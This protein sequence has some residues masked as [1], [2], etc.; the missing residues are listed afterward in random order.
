[1]ERKINVIPYTNKKEDSKNLKMKWTYQQKEERVFI[2]NFSI[3]YSKKGLI[4]HSTVI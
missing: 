1:M 2:K 3:Y 4:T